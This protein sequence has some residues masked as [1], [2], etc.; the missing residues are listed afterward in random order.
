M[1]DKG[2][3]SKVCK[4]LNLVQSQSDKCL[5]TLSSTLSGTAEGRGNTFKKGNLYPVFRQISKI[6]LHCLQIKTVLCQSCIF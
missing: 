1:K 6:F 2:Y 5:W 3:V 4:R